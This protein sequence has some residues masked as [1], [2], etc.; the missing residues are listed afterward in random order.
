MISYSPTDSNRALQI[1]SRLNKLRG[2]IGDGNVE[3]LLQLLE[4][5]NTR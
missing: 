5:A 1:S 3:K 4:S 2:E